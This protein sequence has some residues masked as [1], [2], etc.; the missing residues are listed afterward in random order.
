MCAGP[1]WHPG[2]VEES[3]SHT[4]LE[5]ASEEQDRQE[6]PCKEEWL[7]RCDQIKHLLGEMKKLL[8][9]HL[10]ISPALSERQ[11]EEIAFKKKMPRQIMMTV[12]TCPG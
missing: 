9:G 8:T 5:A 1:L 7:A 4:S 10:N 11:G 3:S 12:S 6:M 2:G